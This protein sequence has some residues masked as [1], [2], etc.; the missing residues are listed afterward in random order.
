MT[1]RPTSFFFHGFTILGRPESGVE[2]AAQTLLGSSFLRC[3]VNQPQPPPF[4]FGLFILFTLSH[5]AALEEARTYRYVGVR[6][7]T[8]NILGVSEGSM[9]Y[10]LRASVIRCTVVRSSLAC[11]NASSSFQTCSY[12]QR[13]ATSRGS[14]LGENGC[15]QTC[16]P[17]C[18]RSFLRMS[19]GRLCSLVTI[20][21]CLYVHSSAAS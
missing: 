3:R 15:T 6:T 4:C 9:R 8:D 13:L 2:I 16:C 5:R 7:R 20:A 18:Y 10:I 14:L 11:V 12:H 1:T 17:C 21:E 19:S